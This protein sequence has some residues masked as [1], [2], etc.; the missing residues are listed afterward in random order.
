MK[1]QL[2]PK[3]FKHIP[4]KST[5]NRNYYKYIGSDFCID[6]EILEICHEDDNFYE[7]KLIYFNH[8]VFIGCCEKSIDIS[9]EIIEI[10]FRNY[11]S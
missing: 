9:N 10:D 1:L 3:D 4:E 5:Y 6:T 2:K 11:Y 8:E 7:F